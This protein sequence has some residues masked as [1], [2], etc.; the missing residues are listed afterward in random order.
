MNACQRERRAETKTGVGMF[1]SCRGAG[2]RSFELQPQRTDRPAGNNREKIKKGKK[3]F[4]E[5]STEK[6]VGVESRGSK[7]ANSG[8]VQGGRRIVQ[9]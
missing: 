9:S 8:L 6:D 5:N 7:G 1:S 3:E 2:Q 4:Y